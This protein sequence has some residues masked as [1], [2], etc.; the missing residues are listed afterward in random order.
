MLKKLP[1]QAID[2]LDRYVEMFQLTSG[3]AR[4]FVQQPCG[5]LGLRIF[6]ED[7][8]IE[9]ELRWHDDLDTNR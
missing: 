4:P 2:F 1:P 3:T 7:G 8:S 6:K 9:C 5:K